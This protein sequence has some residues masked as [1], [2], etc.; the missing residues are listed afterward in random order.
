MRTTPVIAIRLAA[1]LLVTAAASAVHA[2]PAECLSPDPSAWPARSKP[3][4]MV[5]ADSSGSMNA[6]V[7]GTNSCGLPNTR[8]GHL[9]CALRNM[10]SAYAGLANFGLATYAVKQTG[11]DAA[12]TTCVP[13]DLPGGTTGCGPGSGTTRAGANIVVPLLQDD[14][15]SAPDP[16]NAS[17]LLSWFD[18]SCTGDTELFIAGNT[19]LNGAL[20]DMH[21]YLQTQWA[22]P[23]GVPTYATPLGTA[24]QGE[25]ACRKVNVILIT[26]SDENC[27]PLSDA[28]AAAGQLFAGGVTVG[29]NTFPV[30]TWVINL[31]GGTPASLDQ[32]AAAGGTTS[33]F[34]AANETAL[35]QAFG[36]IVQGRLVPETCDNTDND[37]N[38]CTDEGHNHYCDSF[39]TCCGW[40]TA[41][42][43]GTCLASY[44]ASI[45][46]AN[47]KGNTALLPCTT[48]VQSQAPTTWLCY[49]P[50]DQCDN[51][52][53]N[54][55]GVIDERQL[56]CGTPLHCPAPEVCN[57]L[58]DDCDGL[59]DEGCP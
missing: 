46:P 31:A 52:D 47:P 51:A 41:V 1:L 42:Q 54:C 20:R 4:F 6:S 26:D 18:G 3:Y 29:G 21:R 23:G 38:G 2:E 37:C 16:T 13:S 11:C 58:D 9:R 32:I 48:A 55:D 50:A 10:I 34:F 36:N 53:N 14:Y 5:I 30:R 15:W 45:T 57:G 12:C 35:S 39:Q 59:F 19:P 22:F 8:N 40:G 7:T 49:D 33:A 43:R 56:K 27:D 28:V 24:A 44:Q 25:R 17:S